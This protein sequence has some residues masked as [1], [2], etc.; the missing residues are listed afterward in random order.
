MTEPRDNPEERRAVPRFPARA[1]VRV[2]CWA[3]APGPELDA[4]L[5]DVSSAGLRLGLPGALL[6]GQEVSVLLER[7][8]GNNAVRRRGT[9][10]WAQPAAG[11]ACLARVRLHQ[12]LSDEELAR[13]ARL[14]E[15]P[16]EG[17]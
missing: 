7:L 16:R 17:A 9:V 10:A 13:F 6:A 15:G 1:R 2:V 5:L 14:P 11:G 12:P 3:G 4:A 8:P